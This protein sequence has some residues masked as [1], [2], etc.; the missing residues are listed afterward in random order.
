M[1]LPQSLWA[2]PC[3]DLRLPGC[4]SAWH[5]RR[6]RRTSYQWEWGCSPQTGRKEGVP[7]GPP[8]PAALRSPLRHDGVDRSQM[9]CA[10]WG[11]RGCGQPA[12]GRSYLVAGGRPSAV[13]RCPNCQLRALPWQRPSVKGTFPAERG[14]A[15]CG[16]AALV[17][18]HP[19]LWLRGRLFRQPEDR[20]HLTVSK[21]HSTL[22]F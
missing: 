19:G 13:P 12:A 4:S 5:L 7:R 20:V 11:G 18:P 21:R 14:Q 15:S 6:V 9:A 16:L 10:A 17:L 8:S 3:G 22:L 2:E 1:H